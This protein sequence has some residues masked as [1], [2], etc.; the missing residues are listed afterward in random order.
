MY[1]KLV[2]LNFI[3]CLYVF[4]SNQKGWHNIDAILHYLVSDNFDTVIDLA[5]A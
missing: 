5:H 3:N 4:C 2:F 1:T